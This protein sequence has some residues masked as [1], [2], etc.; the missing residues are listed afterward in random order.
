MSTES[1]GGWRKSFEVIK[2]EDFIMSVFYTETISRIGF[3][4]DLYPSVK[5]HKFYLQSHGMKRFMRF[6]RQKTR[7]Q[8]PNS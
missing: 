4:A 8:N 2:D 1:I 6:N 3:G 7:G 5:T